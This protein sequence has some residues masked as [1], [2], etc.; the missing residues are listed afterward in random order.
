MSKRAVRAVRGITE[1]LLN[2]II[3]DHGIRYIT[4]VYLPANGPLT[5]EKASKEMAKFNRITPRSPATGPM[6]TEVTPSTKTHEGATGYQRDARSELFLRATCNF[7]GEDSFYE[8]A[9][10]RDDRLRE[11]VAELAVDANGWQWLQNF[12]PWLRTD[13]NIRSAPILL[14]L[15]A[16]AAR[17][18]KSI[19]GDGNRQLVASVLQ[20][21]DEPGEALAYWMNG[22]GK[23]IPLPIKRGIADAASR[24]YTENGYMRWDKP[25]QAFRFAD[26]LEL[27]HP[28]LAYTEDPISRNRQSAL[29]NWA[30]TERRG[31]DAEPP[32]LLRNIS[33]RRKLSRISPEDRHV[34]ARHVQVGDE[35]KVNELRAAMAHQWEWVLSWLGEYSGHGA[36]SKGEQWELVLPYVGYMAL[37]RNLRNLDEAGIDGMLARELAI[38]IADPEEVAT[39]RQLPFRFLSAYLE[40]PSLRWG[41]SL[42]TAL[43][44]SLQNIPEL[45]GRSLIL[46]DTSGSMGA[47]M[48]ARSKVTRVKAA[49]LFGLALAMKN[50]SSVDVYGFATGNFKVVGVTRGASVLKA[51]ESFER[52]VGNV[53]H[54][55]EIAANVAA[56]YKSGMYNRVFIFTDMQAFSY[57]GR[58][59]VDAVD[60]NVPVYAFN[61]S[62]YSSTAMPTDANRYELGGLTDATFRII[63]SIENGRDGKWPWE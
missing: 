18:A 3:Y 6:R 51:V 13:G 41:H 40:A 9:G 5:A 19:A 56:T 29:F 34:Y 60:A 2:N 22:H 30:I 15:E 27:T 57:Y 25:S 44:H 50:P 7:A 20:R 54:G 43:G 32:P 8:Q 45:K 48:S 21:A 61:L 55:T 37:I 47:L 36:L 11:L 24:L 4:D 14:A 58:S 39:S 62:G 1:V 38:R 31:R 26:V 33:A 28:R 16:V 53:G 17:L 59:A 63:E 49:A 35:D 10:V 52:C 23:A 42:E 46:I 12:L